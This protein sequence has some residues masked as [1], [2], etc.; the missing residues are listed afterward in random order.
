MKRLVA[1]LTLSV[2]VAGIGL[3][4]EVGLG[5]KATAAEPT[6]NAGSSP[7]AG[8]SRYL[9]VDLVGAAFLRGGDRAVGELYETLEELGVTRSAAWTEILA[10]PKL[11]GPKFAWAGVTASAGT[12]ALGGLA[13]MLGSELAVGI[14]PP[15]SKPD[16]GGKSDPDWIL[17]AVVR[18]PDVVGK[19]LGSVHAMAG[20][21]DEA[22][23]RSIGGVDVH[24]SKPDLCHAFTGDALLISNRFE[25]LRDSLKRAKGGGLASTSAFRTAASRVASDAIAWLYADGDAIR[26]LAGVSGPIT[27]RLEEPLGGLLF[28]G[29]AQRVANADLAMAQLRSLPEGGGLRLEAHARSEAALPASHRGF[30]IAES[31]SAARGV[32]SPVDEC[33]AVMTVERDWADLFAERE[34]LLQ[35]PAAAKMVEFAATMTTL[36]GGLDFIEEF[37]PALRGPLQLV[38]TPRDPATT[39]YDAKPLLPAFALVAPVDAPVTA[40]VP[41]VRR[42]ESGALMLFAFVNFEASQRGDPNLL[43]ELE[44]VGDARVLSAEFPPPPSRGR[45]ARGVR[46]NFEPA[47]AC[48]DDFVVLAS[49]REAA[50]ATVAAIRAGT[51]AR[52]SDGVDALRLDGPLVHALLAKNRD[53]LVANRMLKHDESRDAASTAVDAGL[54]WLK[55]V[56]GVEARSRLGE[57][58]AEIVLDVRV[59]GAIP[60]DTRQSSRRGAAR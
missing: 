28:G 34:A 15:A 47:V 27:P 36:L 1:C 10:A 32:G 48:V 54:E 44:S 37:L 26:R 24:V 21:P 25:L 23:T 8:A 60:T 41:W 2:V 4:T 39:T 30:P 45:E 20:L 52:A 35:L 57:K 53:E 9:P 19:M 51:F 38:A 31:T 59:G 14:R 58:D 56:Q 40:G 22:R 12:D 3:S 50:H 49:T 16:E 13:A 55:L 33:M 29:L 46:Y 7:S 6:P 42:F 18:E 43:I 17:V 5:S 11:Q